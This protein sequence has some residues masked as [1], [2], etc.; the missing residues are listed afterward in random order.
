MTRRCRRP[1]TGEVLEDLADGVRALLG[2]ALQG[3]GQPLADALGQLAGQPQDLL[4]ELALVQSLHGCRFKPRGRAAGRQSA[5][6]PFW[7]MMR[8]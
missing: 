2:R 6:C 8:R 7:R 4:Q 1:L 3:G 5:D